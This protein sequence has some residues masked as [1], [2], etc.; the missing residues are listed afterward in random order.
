MGLELEMCRGGTMKTT[1]RFM[2]VVKVE[3]QRVGVTKEML[4]AHD[5]YRE[6]TDEDDML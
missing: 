6:Q 4:E 3:V 2:D 5:L 1:E